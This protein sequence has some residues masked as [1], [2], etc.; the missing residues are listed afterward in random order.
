MVSKN[1]GNKIFSAAAVA[2]AAALVAVLVLVLALVQ[3]PVLVA[4]EVVPVGR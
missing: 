1:T 3:G 4:V 2:A